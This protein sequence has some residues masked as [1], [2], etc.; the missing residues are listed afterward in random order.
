MSNALCSTNASA[1][2]RV[3]PED[4]LVITEAMAEPTNKVALN[5]Q[6]WWELTN[7]G[8]NVVNLHGYRWDDR[9]PSFSGAIVITNDILLPPRRSAIIVSDI[10]AEKFRSWWGEENLPPDLPIITHFGNGLNPMSEWIRLWNPSALNDA[11]WLLETSFVNPEAGVSLWFDPNDPDSEFGLPSVEG[12]RGAFRAAESDDIGSPG[13][14]SNEQRVIRP[15]VTSIRKEP[16]GVRITWKSQPGKTYELRYRDT[17]S[18]T[19][20][21]LSA[22]V[23]A[24][25][26]LTTVTD[27]NATGVTQRFY[28][29]IRVP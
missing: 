15:K 26:D 29:V 12:Q 6:T 8:T 3:L 27:T 1:T 4:W 9:P 5:N 19:N 16:G 18:G 20:W 17:P 10:S 28:Q 21:S 2:L 24:S 14:T 23:V 13:W 25:G 11:E 7:L 22:Q